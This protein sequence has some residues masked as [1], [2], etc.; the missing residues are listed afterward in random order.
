MGSSRAG[1]T[2]RGPATP[3]FGPGPAKRAPGSGGSFAA[4]LRRLAG[5]TVGWAFE[6]IG[7]P[8]PGL[9]PGGGTANDDRP[10]VV[11]LLFGASQD[12]VTA[13]ARDLAASLAAGGPRAMLVLDSPH[14]A[15]ARRAGVIVDHVISRADWAARGYAEWDRYLAGEMDRLRHDLRTRH[16]VTLPPEGTAGM[17][18]PALRELLTAPGR[19]P[20]PLTRLWRR[21]VVRAERLVDRTSGA[22]S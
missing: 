2:T 7:G 22:K 20:N 10:I 21:A 4:R 14:F 13:T 19:R 11:V 18:A 9:V 15:A 1:G 12:A 8:P 3:R 17:G 6:T 16:V 5:D